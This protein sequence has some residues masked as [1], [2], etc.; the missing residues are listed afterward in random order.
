MIVLLTP[1]EPD[2]VVSELRFMYQRTNDPAQ[3]REHIVRVMAAGFFQQ[4]SEFSD[5]MT[6]M[7]DPVSPLLSPLL[8]AD[9]LVLRFEQHDTVWHLSCQAKRLADDHPLYQLSHWHNLN[10]NPHIP[11]ATAVLAFIPDWQHSRVSTA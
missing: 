8:A 6:A 7:F 1:L 3:R 2:H 10:F 5:C 4:P 9:S 11:P